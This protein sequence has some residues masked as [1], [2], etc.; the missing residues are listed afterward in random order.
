[1]PQ[2]TPGEPHLGSITWLPGVWLFEQ[3]IMKS[4]LQPRVHFTQSEF[5]WSQCCISL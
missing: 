2:A 4:E 3:E 5:K 1:M